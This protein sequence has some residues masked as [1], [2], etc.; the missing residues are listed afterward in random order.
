MTTP[1]T[2]RQKRTA[3]TSNVEEYLETIYR[4][5][6]E[7]GVVRVKEISGELGVS[8]ASTSEILRRMTALE[9]V[10]HERYGYVRLTDKGISQA[11]TIIKREEVLFR[12]LH[13]VLCLPAELASSDA[14]RLEHEVSDCVTERLT[15]WIQFME[16]AQE[17]ESLKQ[18]FLEEAGGHR[19]V[20]HR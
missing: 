13:T 8:Y 16:G 14:C 19:C 2:H 18:R 7:K 9:L 12:F 20:E 4:L 15:Q 1:S 17:F 10:H 3:I 5:E 6:R 11:E